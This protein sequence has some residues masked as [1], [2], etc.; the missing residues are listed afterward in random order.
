MFIIY[1]HYVRN[2]VFQ[3]VKRVLIC[4]LTNLVQRL[5]GSSLPDAAAAREEGYGG[6]CTRKY[7][8]SLLSCRWS[9]Q[10]LVSW[11]TCATLES[12]WNASPPRSKEIF[13]KESKELNQIDRWTSFQL[14]GQQAKN[15][16]SSHQQLSVHTAS[17]PSFTN[18]IQ[19]S[20]IKTMTYEIL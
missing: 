3:V 1:H 12:K 14:W 17:A 18:Y 20:V 15:A 16:T 9:W 5:A 7:S 2:Q 4:G 8:T 11:K 19:V 13:M 6:G 10:M